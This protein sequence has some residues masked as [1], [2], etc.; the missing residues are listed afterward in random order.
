MCEAN[1]YMA[2]E[3]KEEMVMSSV[4]IVEPQEDNVWRLVN[5]FGEQKTVQG[6]IQ[7]MNLVNHIIIFEAPEGG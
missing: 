1:V 4:D 3:G 5:I 2:V 6:R 7:S